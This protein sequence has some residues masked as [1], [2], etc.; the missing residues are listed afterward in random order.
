MFRSRA[1]VRAVS[2]SISELAGYAAPWAIHDVVLG[3]GQL[4]GT[5]ISVSAWP[6]EIHLGYTLLVR[7][8]SAAFVMYD[9][10][11]SAR[12]QRQQICHE[13]AHLILDH[14][15]SSTCGD[16]SASCGRGYGDSDEA[17]AELL[18][19]HLAVQTIGTPADRAVEISSAQVKAWLV[20]AVGAGE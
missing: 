19:T 17:A 8:D 2:G 6:D 14:K 4:V 9:A 7:T 18:G 3:V 15:G 16:I 5:S 20:G 12:H 10:S 1:S 13:L 11:R